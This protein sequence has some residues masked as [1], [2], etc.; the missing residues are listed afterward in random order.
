VVNGHFAAQSGDSAILV[1][2]GRTLVVAMDAAAAAH[3]SVHSA[4]DLKAFGAQAVVN[5]ALKYFLDYKS[6]LALLDAKKTLVIKFPKAE[7]RDAIHQLLSIIL[8][9]RIL[10]LI[11]V[12]TTPY[13]VIIKNCS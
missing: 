2:C 13:V 8:K 6:I 9:L 12:S 7:D 3:D 1:A 5:L 11:P 4:A 10:V